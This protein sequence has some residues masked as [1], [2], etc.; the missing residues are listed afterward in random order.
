M[1]KHAV[2]IAGGG[3]TGLMLAGELGRTGWVGWPV[4]PCR[5]PPLCS[6][7]DEAMPVDPTS[8]SIERMFQRLNE[9]ERTG[10]IGR[11][12]IGGAFA[13][14]YYA[15]PFETSD[16]DVFAH[17]PSEGALISL[18]PIYEY[19]RKLGCVE[20]DEH[21]LIEGIPVQILPA[22]GPLVEEAIER[23]QGITIGREA[24]RIFTAEHAV[25]VALKTN[26]AKDRMKILHL[27]ET[28]ATPLNRSEL[29]SILHRHGLIDRW[30]KFEESIGG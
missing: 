11:Y 22:T 24:T 28:A 17:I 20:E 1:T 4:R 25:A 6:G 27:L 15:E 12:A 29:D 9:L 18:A 23:A 26:R 8:A 16:V 5:L 3:P 14:I 21:L 30:R 7:T 2:V 13:F 19:L 10:L